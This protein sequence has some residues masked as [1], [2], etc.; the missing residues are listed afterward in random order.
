MRLNT[1]KENHMQYVI[2]E[3]LG[4]KF[5]VHSVNDMYAASEDGMV[6]NLE[7]LKLS[8]GRRNHTSYVMCSVR[9]MSERTRKN[10]DT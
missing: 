2:I 1:I 6:V 5:V 9:K 8:K 3:I 4:K 10:D 7:S